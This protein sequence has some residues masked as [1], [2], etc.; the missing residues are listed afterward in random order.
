V[1]ARAERAPVPGAIF[2]ITPHNLLPFSIFGQCHCCNANKVATR[3][4]VSMCGAQFETFLR[5]SAWWCVETF[6][7]VH[8]GVMIEISDVTK[9]R[10]EGRRQD[11]LAETSVD[12]AVKTP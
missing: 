6:E 9:A 3:A 12:S 5:G 1:L 8:H 4:G 10:P 7:G 2:E 11:L